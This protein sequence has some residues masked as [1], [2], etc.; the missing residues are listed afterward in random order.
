MAGTVCVTGATG[1][2]ASW[3]IMRLL[4]R[5]YSVRATIRPSTADGRK[6]DLSFLE[7][8][9]GA[10]EKLQIFTADLSDPESFSEAIEGCTG[11]F[12]VATPLDF[13]EPEQVMTQRALDGT[14]G[15]LKA[16]LKSKTVKRV[17]YT[18]SAYALC[19][20]TTGAATMDES[21]WSD[22]EYIRAAKLNYGSYMISKTLSEKA[23]L[24]FGES[25]GLD[26][27]TIVPPFVTGPFVCDKLPDSVRISMAMIFGNQDDYPYLGHTCIVHVDDLASAHIFLFEHPCPK[28]RYICSSDVITTEKMSKFLTE[29]YPNQFPVPCQLKQIKGYEIPILS[30]DK[31]LDSGFEFKHGFEETFHGAIQCCRQKGYL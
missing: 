8:L 5:G 29:K 14:L 26:V 17:I 27:V 1:F 20:N 2:V 13:R 7:S 6:R 3:L 21:Y 30:A 11:V 15:I 16:S 28:G 25:N 12:H 22:V 18:S 9:P 10:P 24:E 23:A 19:V 4:E 31:L